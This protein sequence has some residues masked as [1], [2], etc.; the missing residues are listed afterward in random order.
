VVSIHSQFYICATEAEPIS[1]TS[2]EISLSV[3]AHTESIHS[4]VTS[5]QHEKEE[6]SLG[7]VEANSSFSVTI[8]IVI[9]ENATTPVKDATPYEISI[10]VLAHTESIPKLPVRTRRRAILPN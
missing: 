6:P 4:Q 5:A 8:F 1:G 7:F 9:D 2:Y 10:S 3:L